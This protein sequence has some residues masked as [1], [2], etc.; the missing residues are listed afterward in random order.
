MMHAGVSLVLRTEAAKLTRSKL[1]RPVAVTHVTQSTCPASCPWMDSGC[2][3]QLGPEGR[4]TRRLAASE[5]DPGGSS[6]AKALWASLEEARQIWAAAARAIDEPMGIRGVPLRLRV[7]GDVAGGPG[8]LVT[9]R[10]AAGWVARGGGAPWAYTHRWREVDRGVWGAVNVLA[11]CEDV[12]GAELAASRGYAVALVTDTPID[13]LRGATRVSR[14]MG[15]ALRP[16][17]AIE[18]PQQTGARA[19]CASCMACAR[20]LPGTVL[21]LR[22]HG[23][24]GR[25]TRAMRAK[26]DGYRVIEVGGLSGAR[27]ASHVG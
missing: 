5:G 18:C 25:P 6:D 3:A 14:G 10:A 1:G 20:M 13:V 12:A 24:A 4:V 27:G 11:S 26:L 17:A 21:A 2:Y 19:D 7:V 8:A 15:G 22:P 16:G 23:P 9:G